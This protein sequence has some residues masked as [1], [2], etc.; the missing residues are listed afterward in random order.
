MEGL[1]QNRVLCRS[2]WPRQVQ[3][4][5]SACTCLHAQRMREKAGYREKGR[6]LLVFIPI[7]HPN[8]GGDQ[9]YF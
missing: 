4:V 2:G 8:K 1:S 9:F 5:A 7:I 3:L 6:C